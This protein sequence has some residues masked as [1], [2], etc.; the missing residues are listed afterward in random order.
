LELSGL[1]G[2]THRLFFMKDMTLMATEV[3]YDEGQTCQ[4]SGAESHL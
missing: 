3:Y 1:P 2:G 4:E